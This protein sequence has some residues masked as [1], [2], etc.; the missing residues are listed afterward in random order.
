MIYMMPSH[1]RRSGTT[2][3]WLAYKHLGFI[4]LKI[5]L[6]YWA[7]YLPGGPFEEGIGGCDIS[8]VFE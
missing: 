6:F 8:P 2:R 7:I 1:G 5:E 4:S 3:Q